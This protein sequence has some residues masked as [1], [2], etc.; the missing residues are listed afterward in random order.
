MP[1]LGWSVAGGDAAG[2][3]ISYIDCF[4]NYY[5][6]DGSIDIVD[7]GLESQME[8]TRDP[9]LSQQTCRALE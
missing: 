2:P 1:D 4:N 7:I 3:L 6:K 5:L 8:P 9:Y